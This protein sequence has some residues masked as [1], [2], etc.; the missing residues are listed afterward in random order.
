M[1]SIF[2]NILFIGNS[3]FCHIGTATLSSNILF[4]GN[5]EQ[6]IGAVG[7]LENGAMKCVV[8][9][10]NQNVTSRMSKKYFSLLVKLVLSKNI[11]R[12]NPISQ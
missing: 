4:L 5:R 9:N 6:I 8:A 2:D 10:T 3:C 12:K 7:M 11:Q 1:K